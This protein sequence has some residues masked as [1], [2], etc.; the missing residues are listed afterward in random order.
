MLLVGL[1]TSYPS[2]PDLLT[3]NKESL[4][5]ALL[6]YWELSLNGT[7]PFKTWVVER[8]LHCGL[9]GNYHPS[10]TAR[11]QL[12]EEETFNNLAVLPQINDILDLPRRLKGKWHH[13]WE[14]ALL[15]T[16]RAEELQGSADG[17]SLNATLEVIYVDCFLNSITLHL[18]T[19]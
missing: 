2:T 17:T 3:L 19:W 11:S 4:D 15:S 5:W 6:H 1:Q 8:C 13:K 18:F 14:S 7:T 16:E 9:S 12:L 10:F